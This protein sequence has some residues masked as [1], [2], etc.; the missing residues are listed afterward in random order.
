MTLSDQPDRLPRALLLDMDGTL[1][2]DQLDFAEIRAQLEVPMEVGLLEAMEHMSPERV[3]L[4]RRLLREHEEKSAH[5][6]ELAD[7]CHDLLDF[8][9]RHGIG[10]ALITR[11]TRRSVETVLA[12]HGLRLDTLMTR[13]DEPH[14]PHPAPLLTACQRL[15]VAPDDA[16]MVGDW[17]YDIEAGNAAAIRTV[18]LHHGRQRPFA[19]VPTMA[20]RDLPDLLRLLRS[21]TDAISQK[22]TSKCD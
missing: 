15:G 19:A 22:N 8:A 1:T 16:W 7:G 5:T 3:A 21:L 10:T 20:V 6:S 9:R 13:E 11:N 12:I 4:A 2:R 17:K 14:K 18:W